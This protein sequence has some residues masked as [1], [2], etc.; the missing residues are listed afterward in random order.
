VDS[1]FEWLE[2]LWF[3]AVVILLGIV[4]VK[5]GLRVIRW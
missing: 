5:V 1:F 3:V 2:S 4:A